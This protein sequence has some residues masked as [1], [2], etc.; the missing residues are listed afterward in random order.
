MNASDIKVS[1]KWYVANC[2]EIGI[3]NAI[4]LHCENLEARNTM[5]IGTTALLNFKTGAGRNSVK[6]TRLV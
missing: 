2:G 6:V 4:W 1:K 5:P 3:N